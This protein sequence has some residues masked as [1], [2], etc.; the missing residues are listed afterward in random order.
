MYCVL[1]KTN[2]QTKQVLCSIPNDAR[3]AMSGKNKTNS[4]FTIAM[5]LTRE[6]R[7][8]TGWHF[9]LVWQ[10]LLTQSKPF[11][12]IGRLYPSFWLRGWQWIFLRVHMSFTK[13]LNSILLSIN[14][15]SLTKLLLVRY[16]TIE[17]W[18]QLNF[19]DRNLCYF[20]LEQLQS[21]SISEV[22]IRMTD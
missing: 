7:L 8:E 19:L 5:H 14:F 1:E 9:T 20:V 16:A 3:I 2:K 21:N 12:N 4:T 15:L 11:L 22:E 17:Q 13:K 6:R 18:K 10:K